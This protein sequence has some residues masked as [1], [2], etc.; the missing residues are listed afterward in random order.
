MFYEVYPHDED[1]AAL[2]N[3]ETSIHSVNLAQCDRIGKQ[4][5]AALA[6]RH[7]ISLDLSRNHLSD[8][9]LTPIIEKNTALRHLKINTAGDKL[10]KTIK[11]IAKSK[12]SHLDL[13]CCYLPSL[14]KSEIADLASSQ[15]IKKLNLHHCYLSDESL[16]LLAA[17]TS[18]EVLNLSSTQMVTE[19]G[20]CYFFKHNKTL[21]GIK[22]TLLEQVTDK[23]AYL[24]A[25]HPS[26][27]EVDISGCSKLTEAGVKILTAKPNLKVVYTHA[28]VL[29]QDF[30]DNYPVFFPIVNQDNPQQ[31]SS[32]STEEVKELTSKFTDKTEL[33]NALNIYQPPT[34]FRMAAYQ[35]KAQ[36]IAALSKQYQLLFCHD[37]KQVSSVP[38]MTIMIDDIYYANSCFKM[39]GPDGV[40]KTG[41][42]YD[43]RIN[44]KSAAACLPIVLN[45]LIM[46]GYIKDVPGYDYV[47]D[48]YATQCTLNT[49]PGT[50]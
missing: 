25:Q 44:K 49:Q 36:A 16:K 1:I 47:K 32:L 10:S 12:I 31:R 39:C 4:T 26:L 24:I 19:D 7:L 2:L 50:L 20:L 14:D 27:R 13:E 46:M 43:P 29:S 35:V 23:V 6:N 38:P 18:I 21:T 41:T 34:L 8:E 45:Y 30:K 15:H 33:N 17:N 9:E 28:R 3:A 11:L 5:L 37:A 22:L 40:I 42:I 48:A